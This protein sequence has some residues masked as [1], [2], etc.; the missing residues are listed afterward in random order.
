MDKGKNKQEKGLAEHSKEGGAVGRI[1]VE[2]GGSVYPA[3]MTNGAM[4]RFKQQTGRDL[5]DSDGGFCD[6][7]T[8][9]WCC[10][11][12]ACKREG[13]SFGM[14]LEEFADATDPADIEEWSASMFGDGGD[15]AD[16]DAG[17]KK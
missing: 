8:L 10:V 11:A 6:T 14:S 17:K 1:E 9:L 5:T 3:Y 16:A 7:F 15:D 2:V 12:S 13:V 4:L